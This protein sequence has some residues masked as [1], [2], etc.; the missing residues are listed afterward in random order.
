M[1]TIILE[2]L[3]TEQLTGIIRESVRDEIG[4]LRQQNPET[5]TEYLTRREVLTRLKIDP[6]TLWGWE[7]TGYIQSY[8]FGG[9]KRYKRAD[10]EAI[11]SGKKGT[12]ASKPQQQQ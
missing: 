11:H 4:H 12:L 2:T 5:E 1:A 6:S 8:P 9:R 3:T 7:K 10:V